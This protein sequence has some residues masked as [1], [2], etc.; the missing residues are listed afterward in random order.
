MEFEERVRE[1]ESIKCKE[2]PVTPRVSLESS[3]TIRSQN[4][5]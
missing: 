5:V 4:S 1:R 3:K 2:H